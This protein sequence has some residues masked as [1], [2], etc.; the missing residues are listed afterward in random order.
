MMNRD[1]LL[2]SNVVFLAGV[3]LAVGSFG[4]VLASVFYALSPVAAA[5][6]IPGVSMD[7]AYD[8]VISGRDTMMAAGMIGLI[9]DVIFI[10][11]ALLLTIFR[12]PVSIQI[13]RIGWALVT[14]GV[15]IFI[16]VDALAAG[17]LTQLA[18]LDSTMTA[19][20]GF[21]LLFNIFFIFG[22][23]TVGLGVPAILMGE[24]RSTSSILSKPLAWVGILFSLAGLAASIL[25]FLNVALPQVIGIS[26]AGASLIFGIYGIQIARQSNP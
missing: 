25:Y 3:A 21:K 22:T 11:G 24:L 2:N 12:V 18:A 10:A 14:T 8:G 17:V 13:E 19:F 16:F 4:V 7:S 1:N 20:A 23:I 9:S 6:P 26:I 5:L 15:T